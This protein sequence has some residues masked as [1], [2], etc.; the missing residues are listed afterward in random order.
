M[1]FG[2]YGT[3]QLSHLRKGIDLVGSRLFEYLMLLL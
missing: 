3:T 1:L 2:F